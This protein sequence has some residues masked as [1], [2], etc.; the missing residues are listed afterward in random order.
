MFFCITIIIGGILCFSF[1]FFSCVFFANA[2]GTNSLISAI[3]FQMFKTVK[4]HSTTPLLSCHLAS[5]LP[6]AL[7]HNS[8]TKQITTLKTRAK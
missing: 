4:D 7:Q 2:S 8:K 3:Y 5:V 6:D 1:S